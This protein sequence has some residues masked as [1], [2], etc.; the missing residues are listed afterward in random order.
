M[1]YDP[2]TG[3]YTQ[4]DA[5]VASR[6]KGLLATTNPLVKQAQT[7]GQAATNKRGLL[8]STMG[9]Q[10]GV[11][12]AYD[13]ALAMATPDAATSA[14]NNLSNQQYEQSNKLQTGQLASTEKIAEQQI[15]S[16]E[17]QAQL[18]ADTQTKITGLNID[19]ATKTQ[20]ADL[21]SKA[22][23]QAASLT[24]ESD[25]A[26]L[27]ADTQAAIA[28]MNIDAA[29]KQQLSEIANQQLMQKASL[30]S[31]QAIAQ[32]SADA[33]ER[34][35]NMNVSADQQAKASAAA[36]AI[37]A[38]YAQMFSAITSNDKIPT[39]TRTQY[40]Q[41]AAAER[42]SGYALIEQIYGINLSWAGTNPSSKP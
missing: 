7:L 12:A 30:S 5:S 28:A 40:L 25:I 42:D 22:T 32:L 6:I 8:N 29:S 18:S 33:Q 15:A 9:A 2:Q 35:A 23:L 3:V 10:A 34:I 21:L 27:N 36:A 14:A 17:K 31:S 13:K 11:A 4:E 16:S 20:A 24:N 41:S 19:A 38:N 26:K 37:E 1:P 39:A